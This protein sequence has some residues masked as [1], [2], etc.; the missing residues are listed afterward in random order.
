MSG[1]LGVAAHRSL[2]KG[3]TI[4]AIF[5]HCGDK[6]YVTQAEIERIKGLPSA[7]EVRGMLAK[8]EGLIAGRGDA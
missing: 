8:I 4:G 1:L 7:T 2:P 3:E 6:Y 5:W